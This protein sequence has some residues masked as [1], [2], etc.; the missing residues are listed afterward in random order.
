MLSLGSTACAP[1][2]TRTTSSTPPGVATIASISDVMVR[3][4]VTDSLP[5]VVGGRDI[6][7]RTRERG[8]SELRYLGLD[9]QGKARF[10]R[11]DVDIITN[12]TAINRTGLSLTWPIVGLSLTEPSV[13]VL[14]PETNE[15]SLDLRTYNS[16]TIHGRTVH[17]IEATS[18]FVRFELRDGIQTR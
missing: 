16:I 3:I 15:F 1:L 17:V 7:G 18:A 5:N 9:A 11:R 2:E 12:E 14:A 4:Q 6:F 10:R 8:F 13:A